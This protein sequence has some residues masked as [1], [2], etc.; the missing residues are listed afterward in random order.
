M[1]YCLWDTIKAIYWP[2]YAMATMA[3]PPDELCISF[4]FYLF[5][6]SCRRRT[7]RMRNV[8]SFHHF[9]A[10]LCFIKCLISF[11]A[12][13]CHFILIVLTFFLNGIYVTVASFSFNKLEQLLVSLFRASFGQSAGGRCSP[14]Y[15]VCLN[16]ERCCN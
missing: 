3:T 13:N 15:L 4:S 7:R 14:A 9:Y 11:C 2:S 6:F 10:S 12:S 8:L 5:I 16:V 1:C